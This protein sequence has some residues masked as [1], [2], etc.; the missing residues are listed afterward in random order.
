V[1]S[2]ADIDEVA[3]KIVQ[4]F[5]PEKIV[6]FGSHARGTAGPDS[7]VDMLVIIGFEGKPFWKSVEILNRI[8]A[9]F[10]I[11]LVARRPDETARRY[12]EGDGLSS[13]RLLASERPENAGE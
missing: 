6:L 8:D 10:P 7:D 2:T 13:F 5:D 11:D 4:E 1:I 12:A 3:E 9:P